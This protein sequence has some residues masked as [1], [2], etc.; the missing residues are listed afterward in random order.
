MTLKTTSYLKVFS[1]FILIVAAITFI[2]VFAKQYL[3]HRYIFS[4]YLDFIFSVI[5]IFGYMSVWEW[6]RHRLKEIEKR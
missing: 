2:I 1:L 3:Q 5:L 6:L 4:I